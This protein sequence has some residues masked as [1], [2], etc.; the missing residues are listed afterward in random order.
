MVADLVEKQPW[1]LSAEALSGLLAG[2]AEIA[3]ETSTGVR[4]NDRDGVIRIR[5]A[6]ASLAFSLF[7][8]C[9]ES[10]LDEPEPIRRWRELCSDP[11]E[12]SEVK[13]SWLA[14]GGQPLLSL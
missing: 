1:F 3:E 7:E 10:G 8:Y 11:D 13:N 4:G 5:A 12:F 2:L 6:A 14:A 9:R